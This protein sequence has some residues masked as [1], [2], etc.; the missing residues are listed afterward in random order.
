M[1]KAFKTMLYG[2]VILSF[3]LYIGPI[4]IFPQFVGWLL[5]YKGIA[6]FNKYTSDKNISIAKIC[7]LGLVIL[8]FITGFNSYILNG[9]FFNIYLSIFITM[10][11]TLLEMIMIHKVFQIAIK[12]LHEKEANQ[13][14][15]PLILKDKIYM[16]FYASALIGLPIQIYFNSWILGLFFLVFLLIVKISLMITLF[17]LS[18]RYEENNFTV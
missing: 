10:F 7:A 1:G 2:L 3:H 6:T 17:R 14:A 9:M 4:K 16:V 18:N 5:I 12:N 11:S 8:S 15:E 13:V